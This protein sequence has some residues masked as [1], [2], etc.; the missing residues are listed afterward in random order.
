MPL[1]DVS[2]LRTQLKAG[3][4]APLYLFVGDDA[5]LIDRMIDA[6]EAVIDEPDRPF[7][8]ERVYAGEENAAP[9]DI[10][11]AARVYPMLGDR[12]I[13]FVLRA[14]RLLKPKRARAGDGES[15]ET[16]GGAEEEGGTLDFAPLEDY[17]AKPAP[18]STLVFVASEV[19]RSRRFTKKLVEKAQVVVFAGLEDGGREEAAAIVREE[20]AREGRAIDPAAL[21]LLVERSAGDITKLR[22]DLERLLLY[23]AD[24]PN[25]SVADVQ[26]IAAV[27]TVVAD[28]WALVNAISGGNA[29]VALREA[30]ARFDRG[31][32]PHAMVGQLRWW[33]SNRL[34][35]GAPERVPAALDALLRTDMALKS[36]GGED[37]VLLERL[38]V[39]LTGRPV[40]SRG[41]PYR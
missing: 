26:E 1:V 15:G 36:S 19:D 34:A 8:V 18:T 11:A 12:R 7:A 32:S 39:E 31:D 37:R 25:V 4:L 41:G 35:E 16:E 21:S 29:A 23:T 28:D 2:A 33:V 22:N 40:A 17:V 9:V 13:V 30:A 38:I 5:R 3:K 20:L 10:A 27:E 24:A 6:V 14:E